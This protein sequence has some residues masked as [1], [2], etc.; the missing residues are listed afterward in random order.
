MLARRSLR[1]LSDRHQR[2]LHEGESEVVA[3]EIVA[4]ELGREA[5]H[6]PDEEEWY[7]V[8]YSSTG[9][10]VEVKSTWT[11]VGDEYPAG[12]RFRLWRAQM[13]SLLAS[14]AAGTAWVAFVLFDEASGEVRVRR[15]RPST[16]W[17]WVTDDRGGW[18]RSG[19]EEWDR[20]HKLPYEV[21][22]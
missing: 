4:E 8:R 13:R 10:K 7:D 15:A 14:D 3:E 21:V 19:H 18:N 5:K 20:Q 9:T 1:D 11:E 16:V 17:S 22:F 12:G 2:M 6:R